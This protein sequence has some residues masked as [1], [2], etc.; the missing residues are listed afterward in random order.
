MPGTK[1]NGKYKGAEEDRIDEALLSR[2]LEA[3]RGAD[4]WKSI[5]SI[6]ISIS[7][8]KPRVGKLIEGWGK[9]SDGIKSHW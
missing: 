8:G 2:E 6:R 9:P 1:V 3:S 4:I 7:M 5:P